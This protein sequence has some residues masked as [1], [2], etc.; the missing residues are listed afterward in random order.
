[1]K[2]S[3]SSLIVGTTTPASQ[4]AALAGTD[5]PKTTNDVANN[6]VSRDETAKEELRLEERIREV[7]NIKGFSF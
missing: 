4:A 7:A 2:V 6:A 3:L 1:M 5:P